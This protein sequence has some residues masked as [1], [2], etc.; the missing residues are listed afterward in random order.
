MSRR[1][2]SVSAIS[3]E[4]VLLGFLARQPSHGYDLHHRLLAELG[5][6]W[7]IS[8]SQLYN[9]LKR[10]EAQGDIIADVQEQPRLPDRHI[11]HLTEQGNARFTKWLETPTGCSVRAI[12]VEFLSR[13]YFVYRD[14][15]ERVA[16]LIQIQEEEIRAGLERLKQKLESLSSEQRFNRLGL[17]LRIQQL[18]SALDWLSECAA[19]LEEA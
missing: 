1:T 16:R 9:I 8:Q 14:N 5:Q 13:L 3:P 12:R 7:R 15:P 2:S 17:E 6:V 11:Y 10:L 19:V 18:N 4:F